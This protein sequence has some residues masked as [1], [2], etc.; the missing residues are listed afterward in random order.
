MTLSPSAVAPA[1]RPGPT[2]AARHPSCV[3]FLAG[4]TALSLSTL[5]PAHAESYAGIGVATFDGPTR[6]DQR[7][8]GLSLHAGWRWQPQLAIEAGLIDQRGDIEL[9]VVNQPLGQVRHRWRA[10]H[11]GMRWFLPFGE[12]WHASAGLSAAHVESERDLLVVTTIINDLDTPILSVT[13]H[14]RSNSS[15]GWL[16]RLGLGFDLTPSQRLSLDYQHLHAALKQRCRPATDGP[17]CSHTRTG[18]G[19]MHL[20]WSYAFR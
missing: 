17:E 7:S 20:S 12:R 16:G 19:G 10:A 5:R 2:A 18:I 15:W 4:I 9:A 8:R 11:A 1:R 13:R 3:W 14:S 6:F